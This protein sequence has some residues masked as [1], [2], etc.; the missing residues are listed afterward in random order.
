MKVVSNKEFLSLIKKITGSIKSYEGYIR[1]KNNGK[2]KED[3]PIEEAE[4]LYH[5]IN[6]KIKEQEKWAKIKK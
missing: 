1:S 2:I 6:K 3:L 4:K 5:Y